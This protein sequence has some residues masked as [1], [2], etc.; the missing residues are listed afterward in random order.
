MGSGDGLLAYRLGQLRP[1]LTIEG[2][3]VLVRAAGGG[4]TPTSESAHST[5]RFAL[6]G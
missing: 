5:A 2:I 1:D 3:D 6:S 4:R